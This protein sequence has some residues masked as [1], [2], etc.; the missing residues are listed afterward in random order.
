[1]ARAKVQP[2]PWSTLIAQ[3]VDQEEKDGAEDAP[4]SEDDGDEN[5][6]AAAAADVKSYQVM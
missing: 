6:E 2:S 1:M 5:A 4:L 3:V